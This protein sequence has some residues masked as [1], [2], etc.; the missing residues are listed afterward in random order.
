MRIPEKENLLRF[1]RRILRKT[2]GAVKEN[3]V[4]RI[5]YN[6]RLH[7]MYSVPNL[8]QVIKAFFTTKNGLAIYS[9]MMTTTQKARELEEDPIQDG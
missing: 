5:L 6:F 8:I 7:R 9:G 1:E 3:G 2:D 4:W